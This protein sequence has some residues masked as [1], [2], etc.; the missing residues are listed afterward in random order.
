M[1]VSRGRIFGGPPVRWQD[2]GFS[3]GDLPAADLQR[4]VDLRSL[5]LGARNVR[6]ATVPSLTTKRRT[7]RPMVSQLGVSSFLSLEVHHVPVDQS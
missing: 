2:V 1:A 4:L 5:D 3:A 7:G 6:M